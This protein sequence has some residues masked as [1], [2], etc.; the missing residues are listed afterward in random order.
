[1]IAKKAALTTFKEI[2]PLHLCASPQ[3][4]KQTHFSLMLP[5]NKNQSLAKYIPLWIAALHIICKHCKAQLSLLSICYSST[6]LQ[7]YAGDG[8]GRVD[9]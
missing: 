6:S 9:C 5:S 3:T 2:Q 1:M 7:N 4:K 8:E